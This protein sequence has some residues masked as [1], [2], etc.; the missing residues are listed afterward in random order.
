[1]TRDIL[2]QNRKED[3]VALR[4]ETALYKV[5][6]TCSTNRNESIFQVT[7]RTK[8]QRGN[9]SVRTFAGRTM[10]RSHDQNDDRDRRHGKW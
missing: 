7:S 1:M 10:K 3:T 9:K 6:L 8:R 2:A 5:C 4:L